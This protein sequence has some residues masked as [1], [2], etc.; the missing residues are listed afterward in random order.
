MKIYLQTCDRIEY[1]KQVIAS[2]NKHVVGSYEKYYADDASQNKEMAPMLE[3]HGW[4]PLFLNKE[5]QGVA[6]TRKRAVVELAQ[7]CGR[8]EEIVFLE[9]DTPIVRQFYTTKIRRLLDFCS[10]IRLYGHYWDS[11]QVFKTEDRTKWS[12]GWVTRWEP[13]SILGEDL[14]FGRARWQHPPSVVRISFALKMIKNAGEYVDE[15][16]LQRQEIRDI[17]FRPIEN[18]TDHIGIETTKDKIR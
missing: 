1:T 8:D 15:R 12:D 18:W 5:R 11:K 3:Q 16:Y 13:I 17:T 7:R 6:I 9:N 10:A 2:V 4:E 14:E